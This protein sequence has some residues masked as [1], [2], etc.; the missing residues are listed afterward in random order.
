MNSESIAFLKTMYRLRVVTF[1]EFLD[2]TVLYE[3]S[4]RDDIYSRY[5]K[6]GQ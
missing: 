1:D 6:V 5:G 3:P 2:L 4:D